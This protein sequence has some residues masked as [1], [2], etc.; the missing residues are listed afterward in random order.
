MLRL[1]KVMGAR[2]DLVAVVEV[3]MHGRLWRSGV[4]DAL[5]TKIGC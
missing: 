2:T 1:E 5:S 3:N 4:D